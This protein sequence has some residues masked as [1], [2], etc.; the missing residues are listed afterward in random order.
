ILLFFTPVAIRFRRTEPAESGLLICPVEYSGKPAVLSDI[1]VS[2]PGNRFQDLYLLFPGKT[3]VFQDLFSQ[4][5]SGFFVGNS[6]RILK[7][8]SDIMEQ[9][10]SINDFLGNPTVFFQIFY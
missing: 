5:F 9:R 3:A 2:V 1:F 7:I 8:S 6:F 4:V 10:R